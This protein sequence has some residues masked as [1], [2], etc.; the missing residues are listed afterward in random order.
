MRNK[1]HQENGGIAVSF[2]GSILFSSNELCFSFFFLLNDEFLKMLL[3]EPKRVYYAK[4]PHLSLK[5]KE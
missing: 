5:N 4:L 2:N 3:I 1:N